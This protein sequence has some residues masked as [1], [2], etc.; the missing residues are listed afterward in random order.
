MWQCASG[1]SEQK[2]QQTIKQSANIL[3]HMAK[4]KEQG[5]A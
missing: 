2:C 5:R 1:Q 3:R 4:Q